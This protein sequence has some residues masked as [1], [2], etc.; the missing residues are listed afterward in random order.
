MG[1]PRAAMRQRHSVF[2][3]VLPRFVVSTSRAR[4]TRKREIA[5]RQKMGTAIVKVGYG[6]CMADASGL[7][8]V[9][10]VLPV[11]STKVRWPTRQPNLHSPK[12]N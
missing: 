8:V 5:W 9:P 12:G 10:K 3:P 11:R 7:A 6:G 1:A 2:A 4:I